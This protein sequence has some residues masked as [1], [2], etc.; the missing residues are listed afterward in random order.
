MALLANLPSPSEKRIAVRVT[1]DAARQ[2]RGGHP[3]VYDESITSLSHEGEPGDLAVLFDAERAFMAIGLFDPQSPIRIKLLHQ[4]KPRTVNADF[5]REQVAAALAIRQPLVARGNTTG[6]RCINGENDN[7]PGLVLDRYDDTLVIKLYTAAWVPHL[8]A[9]LPAVMDALRPSRVILR[10]SRAVSKGGPVS[11]LHDL[12]EG[13]ALVGLP[14]DGPV[15]FQ[16]NGLTFEADVI[17]GQ[18]TGYYLDQRDNRALVG[19]ASRGASVLDVFASTGGFGVHAAAGGAK[20]VT[21][22]DLSA[23]ALAAASRNFALNRSITDVA[24]CHHESMAGDAFEVMDRLLRARREFDVVVVDPPSFAQRQ[25][26]VERGLH[27]YGELTR[28]AVGLVRNGGLLVQASCSS[29]ITSD[30]FYITV[31]RAAGNAG[32]EF[33]DERRTAHGIDHPVTFPQGAYLKALFATVRK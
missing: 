23:P 25:T 7:F 28:R 32:A 6:Y 2:V 13:M 21:S 26:S 5:W 17:E 24:T 27:A 29:R 1:A 15:L 9:L 19:K 16:E 31:R 3:W 18:K 4:G 8:N 11:L 20:D 10:L 12:E 22:V 14:P 30:D 33:E